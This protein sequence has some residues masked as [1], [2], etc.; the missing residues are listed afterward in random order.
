MTPITIIVHYSEIGLKKGNRGFFEQKLKSNIE[1]TLRDLSS[2]FQVRFDF[3]RFLLFVAD[4]T[5]LE[6]IIRRLKCVLGIAHFYVAY[7]GDP[8]IHVLKDQ[9]YDHFRR[10]KFET[11][12]IN[13][14]RADKSFPLNSMEINR[15][16]GE[17]ISTGMKKKVDLTD[18]D[19]RCH[20]EIFNKKI[21]FSFDRHDGYGGLPVGS[22]GKVVSLLS[23]GIDSPV[24]SFRMMTRGCRVVFVHFHSFPFT[25]KSSYYNAIELAKELTVYQNQSRIYLVPLGDIQQAIILNVPAKLRLILYRRMMLRLAEKIA[26]KEKAKAL[27]TGESVGQVASQTLAREA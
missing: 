8:D 6:T 26:L 20:I 21:Y 24:A 16:V 5:H 18:P 25:E 14:R 17:R 4:Q 10:K 7:S 23:S 27:V 1:K 19:I 2:A 3:G 22:S 12:S 15:I 11:F 13:A 9:I